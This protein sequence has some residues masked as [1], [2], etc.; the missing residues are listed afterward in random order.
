MLALY[1]SAR[2]V[3]IM[4]DPVDRF[5]SAVRHR[6]RADSTF[7]PDEGVLR[8]LKDPKHLARSDYRSTLSVL[9]GVVP[10]DQTLA[11]FY[12]DL[13]AVDD[14][15]TLRRITSFLGIDFE[16]GDRHERAYEGVSRAMPEAAGA[17]VLDRLAD[18]YRYAADRFGTV[19]E[20]WRARL[21]LL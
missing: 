10:A 5:W 8:C 14:D 9:D 19:P 21:D 17:A 18:Q 15:S 13:F 1:P 7:D 6:A 16:P 2:L 4:Q 3:F 20:R 12:E 11:V